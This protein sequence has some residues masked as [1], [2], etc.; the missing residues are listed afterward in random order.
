MVDSHDSAGKTVLHYAC[1]SRNF[2]AAVW[3]LDQGAD[4]N[5]RDF[6]GATPIH[7]LMNQHTIYCGQLCV[8]S[9]MIGRANFNLKDANGNTPLSYAVKINFHE[10]VKVMLDNGADKRLVKLSGLA[11]TCDTVELLQ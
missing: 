8:L 9:K 11:L 10:A 7:R 2:D 1:Q 4:P 6:S 5:F 3:L